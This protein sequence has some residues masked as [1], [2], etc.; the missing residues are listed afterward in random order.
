[1]CPIVSS[2]VGQ[3]HK[4]GELQSLRG[5]ETLHSEPDET[6]QRRTKEKVEKEERPR[7]HGGWYESQEAG[8]SAS[9]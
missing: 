9:L 3:A 7:G 4:G 6:F 2:Y 8:D 1:M 5:Q